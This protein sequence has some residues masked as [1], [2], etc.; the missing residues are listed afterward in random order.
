MNIPSNQSTLD[1]AENNAPTAAG[2]TYGC[3]SFVSQALAPGAIPGFSNYST[4]RDM[5]IALNDG[6]YS[7]TSID[8][9]AGGVLPSG[10]V[11]VGTNESNRNPGNVLDSDTDGDVEWAHT[12]LILGNGTSGGSGDG[13]A[14]WSNGGPA[15][16]QGYNLDGT[17]V[18]AGSSGTVYLFPG[19]C[20]GINYWFAYLAS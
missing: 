18:T 6:G 14:Q 2:S 3:A 10:T 12:F 17:A 11:L 16:Q 9:S 13:T 20:G 15:G 4:I 5:I 8:P 7:W 1:W 19:N